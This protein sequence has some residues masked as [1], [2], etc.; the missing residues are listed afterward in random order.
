MFLLQFHAMMALAIPTEF[1]PFI[2]PF[3][4]TGLPLSKNDPHKDPPPLND[5]HPTCTSEDDSSRPY[6]DHSPLHDDHP[7][8]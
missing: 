2:M 6:D 3:L 7:T 1:T 4:P 5:D 8:S